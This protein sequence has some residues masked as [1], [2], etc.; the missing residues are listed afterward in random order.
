[1]CTIFPW[2]GIELLVALVAPDMFELFVSM[3]ASLISAWG[4]SGLIPYIERLLSA[5]W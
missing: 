3:I 5:S 4:D 1:L 2:Y